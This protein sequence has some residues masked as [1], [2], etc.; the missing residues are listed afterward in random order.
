MTD[1]AFDQ[2]M[3]GAWYD[4][5]DPALEA[6]RAT[7]RRAMHAHRSL[8]PETRGAMAPDL[9][10]LLGSVGPDCFIEAPFHASYGCNIHLGAGVYLNAG[11]TILD[12]AAVTVGD[13]TMIGPA[14]QIYCADH[15]RDPAHRSAGIE[16]GL[17]V[18]IGAQVW[19]GG[20]AVIL[21][22]VTIGDGAIIAAGAVVTRD[23]AAGAMVRGTP[24]RPA[25]QSP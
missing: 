8:P 3:R 24:A 10:A 6:L 18:T 23:V 13:R 21:P 12:S 11:V 9:K 16:R 15:H 19:I 2:M 4:G 17:P 20:A 1:S 7:A 5:R 14:A 25:Y 22:G